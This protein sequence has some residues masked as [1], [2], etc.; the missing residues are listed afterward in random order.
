MIIAHLH[1]I[2]GNLQKIGILELNCVLRIERFDHYILLDWMLSSLLIGL[3]PYTQA[4]MQM[5]LCHT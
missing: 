3:T 2:K 1:G 5:I 4:L